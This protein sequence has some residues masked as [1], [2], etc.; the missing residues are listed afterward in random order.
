M[1]ERIDKGL[2]RR[3]ALFFVCCQGLERDLAYLHRDVLFT[4]EAG[5]LSG[6]Q[7][8][9]QGAQAIDICALIG[10]TRIRL[11]FRCAIPE[12][13]QFLARGCE[14]GLPFMQ[15][16]RQTEIDDLGLVGLVDQDVAGLEIPVDHAA[17]VRVGD[18]LADFRDEGDGVI[19][20][21]LAVL[22]HILVKRQRRIG[23]SES[24]DPGVFLDLRIIRACDILHDD[25]GAVIIFAERID[26]DDVHMAERSNGAGL[27]EKALAQCGDRLRLDVQALDG[28]KAVQAFVPGQIDNAHAA[29][30]DFTV[31]GIVIKK[32][33]GA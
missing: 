21:V 8:I 17:A 9:E 10:L 30:A 3:P 4:E 23:L 6:Q 15:E 20:C 12:G 32:T 31:D 11:L 33:V 14:V 1:Y 16:P 27:I 28:D 25:I 26:V 7:K 18:S 2:C 13:E 22:G 29:I 24:A 19:Q 5:V